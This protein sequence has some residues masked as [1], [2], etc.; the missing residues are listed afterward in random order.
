MMSKIYILRVYDEDEIYEY[1][2]GNLPHAIEQQ[3][4]EPLRSEI[5][6]ADTVTGDET[7]IQ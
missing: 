5:W 3:R 1:E 6:I 4:A 2:F 7:R